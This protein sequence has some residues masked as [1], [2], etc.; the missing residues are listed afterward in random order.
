VIINRAMARDYISP[1]ATPSESMSRSNGDDKPY[2]IV[3]MVGDAKYYEIREAA[4]RTI[5]FNMYCAVL[6]SA[7]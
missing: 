3:G 2:E 7:P 5:Y 6:Y 1:R 4:P